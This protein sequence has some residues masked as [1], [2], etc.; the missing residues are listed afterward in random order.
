MSKRNIQKFAD[1][2]SAI[3]WNHHKADDLSTSETMDLITIARDTDPDSLIHAITAAYY[4]GYAV[5]HRRGSGG[6]AYRI[7]TAGDLLAEIRAGKIKEEDLLKA[8]P[9]K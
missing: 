3:I 6:D 1:L 8:N 9:E 7:T 2:G 5:G 4:M